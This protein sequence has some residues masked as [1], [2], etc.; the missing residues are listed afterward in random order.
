VGLSFY[1]L[2]HNREVYS[3]RSEE[4]ADFLER[5][6]SGMLDEMGEGRYAQKEGRFC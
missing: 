2:R 4:D 3:E 5:R 6:L 1:Y